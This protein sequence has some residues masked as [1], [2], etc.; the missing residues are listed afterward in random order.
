MRAARTAS[1]AMKKVC[2]FYYE[3]TYEY[4]I[5]FPK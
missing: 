5:I 2:L 1:V 4:C 3:Y